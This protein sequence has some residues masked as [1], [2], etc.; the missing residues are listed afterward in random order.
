MH[1]A[2]GT[3]HGHTLFRLLVDS[4]MEFAP[5]PSVIP[6]R[7]VNVPLPCSVDPKTGGITDKVTGL[8]IG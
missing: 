3:L 8:A 2:R 7:L 4:Q 5:D 1:V 6:P